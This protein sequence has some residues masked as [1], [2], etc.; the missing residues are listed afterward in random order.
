MIFLHVRAQ[1]ST[2]RPLTFA[3]SSERPRQLDLGFGREEKKFYFDSYSYKGSLYQRKLRL[4]LFRYYRNRNIVRSLG[5]L[6]PE[7]SRR[8]AVQKNENMPAKKP[9]KTDDLMR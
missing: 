9:V 4:D 7:A 5:P 8:L 1:K 6:L 3:F 2:R